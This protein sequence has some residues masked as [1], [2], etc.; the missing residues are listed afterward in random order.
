MSV[1]EF[2]KDVKGSAR[3]LAHKGKEVI[4][5]AA[6]KSKNLLGKKRAW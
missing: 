5:S 4:K 1:K 2:A 6:A 3:N